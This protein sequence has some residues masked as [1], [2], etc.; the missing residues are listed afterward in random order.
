M[1]YLDIILNEFFLFRSHLS[2]KKLDDEI[3]KL[4][5][6]YEEKDKDQIRNMN[7]LD[8]ACKKTEEKVFKY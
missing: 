8:I 1:R 7:G 3:Q 2:K 4:K 5:K 6:L